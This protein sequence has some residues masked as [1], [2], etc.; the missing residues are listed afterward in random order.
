MGE[1]RKEYPTGLVLPYF[2][3]GYC[4]ENRAVF[5]GNTDPFFSS[6]LTCPK[7]EGIG[8][9]CLESVPIVGLVESPTVYLFCE[10]PESACLNWTPSVQ[11]IQEK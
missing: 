9:K 5:Q 4:L 8:C 10:E 2:C 7:K 6:G 1:T 11:L 3:S